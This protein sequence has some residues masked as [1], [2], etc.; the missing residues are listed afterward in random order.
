MYSLLSSES[1]SILSNAGLRRN[2]RAVYYLLSMVIPPVVQ[3]F[4]SY[5]VL[6]DEILLSC[7]RVAGPDAD[8]GGKPDDD[9]HQDICGSPPSQRLAGTIPV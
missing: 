4:T 2:T 5:I 7:V 1:Q 3:L 8:G 9:H 6:C